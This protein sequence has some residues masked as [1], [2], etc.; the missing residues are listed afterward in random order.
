[1]Y[2]HADLYFSRSCCL[3][4]V[5]EVE[6]YDLLALPPRNTKKEH[7]ITA[8]IYAQSYFFIGTIMTFFS[9]M[10][11]FLYLKEYTGVG[12]QDLVFSF[13]NVPIDKLKEGVSEWDFYNKHVYTAQCVCFVAL[14]VM[15]WG[16]IL[17]V[18]NRRL[19][20]LQASPFQKERH[21]LWLFGGIFLSF[22]IA[23][24]VTEVPSIQNVM[25]TTSVPLKYWLLPIPCAVFI[26]M[27]DETRK[28]IVR[29]YPKG[30]L[31]RIAP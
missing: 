25:L 2:A 30:F 29:S 9:N 26:L 1:M 15:Q 12:F 22:M 7:L 17:S 16:N 6:E 4:L 31:A 28:L 24:F 11:A 5:F 8:K 3:A 18:R 19:S 27:A 10:L 14:V 23:V 13:G 21:N 20:I